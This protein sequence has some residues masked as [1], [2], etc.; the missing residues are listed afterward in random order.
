MHSFWSK[1]LFKVVVLDLSWLLVVTT[2]IKQWCTFCRVEKIE[3]CSKLE[4]KILTVIMFGR[5]QLPIW[6]QVSGVL[7]HFP[8]RVYGLCLHAEGS[9]INYSKYTFEPVSYFQKQSY[10]SSCI[11]LIFSC[12]WQ[13]I[14]VWIINLNFIIHKSKLKRICSRDDFYLISML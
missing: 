10:L 8:G 12:V 9:F 2:T 3:K 11:H 4:Y 14:S 13:K 6:H 7:L 5:Y 1:I